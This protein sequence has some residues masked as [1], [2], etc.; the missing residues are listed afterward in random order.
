[1]QRASPIATFH[2][3]SQLSCCFVNLNVSTTV[4]KLFDGQRS[5]RPSHR[6]FKPF[7]AARALSA[8][9]SPRHPNWGSFIG[10]FIVARPNPG[11]LIRVPIR[12]H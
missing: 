12:L 10:R 2:F 5:D 9:L 1:M 8:L 4:E 3:R 11:H 6:L 7:R